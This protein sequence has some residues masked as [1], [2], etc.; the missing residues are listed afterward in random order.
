M[1]GTK[2]I[3]PAL[4]LYLGAYRM[5]IDKKHLKDKVPRGNGTLCQLLEIK[6]K[7]IT[8]SYK[9]KKYYGKK[10]WTVDAID[11]EWVECKLVNKTGLMLQL[12]TQIHNY[13]NQLD[14]VEKENQEQKH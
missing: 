8:P 11:I 4:C 12:E 1:M 9:C 6:L 13:T 2:H 3:H 14:L 7:D 5:C 10:V